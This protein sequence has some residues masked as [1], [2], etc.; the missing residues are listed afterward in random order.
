MPLSTKKVLS[1]INANQQGF[2]KH[3][4]INSLSDSTIPKKKKS[5]RRKNF[6]LSSKDLNTIDLL[7]SRLTAIGLLVKSK[8]TFYP[9]T[10]FE[11]KVQSF[12]RGSF[13]VKH[14]N[15]E[16]LVNLRKANN[17]KINDTVTTRII[18]LKYGI[19]YGEIISVKRALKDK[20]T[21]RYLFTRG[22]LFVYALS[23]IPG[24]PHVCAER[25]KISEDE[26]RF[27]D[28]NMFYTV[29]LKKQSISGMQVCEIIDHYHYDDESRDLERIV[30]RLGLPAGTY[31]NF[32]ISLYDKLPRKDYTKLFTITIDG[33]DAKDFDDAISLEKKSSNTILYVHIADV[34]AYIKKGDKLDEEAY[35]RGTS[36]Y[37]GNSVIPMLPEELCNDICSLKHDV[38]RLTLS[39]EMTFNKNYDL[40]GFNFYRGIIKVDYRLTYNIAEE[41][42][43]SKS[44]KLIVKKLKSMNDL[45]ENLFKK[46]ITK[47]RLDLNLKDTVLI[48]NGSNVTGI[49]Y[50]E[51]LRSHKLIEEFMLTAN[52]VVA[53]YMKNKNVPCLYR[54]HEDIS[55][56]KFYSLKLFLK[57]YGISISKSKNIGLAIQKILEEISGKEYEHVIS[58]VILK[59]M[60]QAYY[61]ANPLGHFGLGF[62]DYTHFTS[63]IRRY[64]DLIV[65]RCLKIIMDNEQPVYSISELN[66]IGEQ[67]SELERT[68][69]KAER[70]MVKLKS[71]RLLSQRIGETFYAIISG[72][73]RHGMFVT[74]KE[75]P[76]EGMVPLKNLTDD[77][78]LINE[79]DFTII[80]RKYSKRFRLGDNI[81]VKL[82]QVD[83][84]NLRIDFSLV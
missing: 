1:C 81:K 60:M 48:Y 29:E 65:H 46:R 38:E 14:E 79:D 17:A 39:A 75:S 67:S 68:A 70:D 66:T 37:I 40:V 22:G 62:E 25:K 69:Q 63:P 3:Q 59:S 56:E 82:S 47:G 2:S 27:R 9:Q 44:S 83:I 21:A 80:G 18:D 36:Y 57:S 61:G 13:I 4:L 71:C 6:Y 11:G 7:L 41:M 16:I 73:S 49:Q 24:N 78:Y 51:R 76:I 55:P 74:L 84:D 64:P 53:H 15:F 42:L 32:S 45:A 12:S 28:K 50:A 20:Y 26:N 19:L 77:F 52:E 54:V 43:E 23:D 35:K 10:E 34:S 72:L 58:L 33:A 5:S 31:P 8:K 30:N